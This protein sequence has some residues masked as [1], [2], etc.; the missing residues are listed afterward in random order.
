MIKIKI[1]T[2]ILILIL[3]FLLL[4]VA[5][6]SIDHVIICELYPDTYTYRDADEYMAIY[7]PTNQTIDIS[8]WTISDGEGIITFP[9]GSNIAE[10]QKLLITKN[11]VQFRKESKGVPDFEYGATDLN[12]TQMSGGK[13]QL[14][15]GGDEL[16]LSDNEGKPVDVVIYGDSGYIGQGWHGPSIGR[17]YEGVI[18]ERDIEEE[19]LDT[20]SMGDWNDLR[21]YY[22][23]QSHFPVNSF[24]FSGTV[25]VFVSPDCSYEVVT[26]AIDGSKKSL[27]IC[28][29][30]FNNIGIAKHVIN[31]K[32]R[33]VDVRMLLEG[34]PVDA[35]SQESRIVSNEIANAG[36]HVSFMIENETVHDRYRYIHAKYI[37]ID[38]KTTL[39]TTENFKYTGIPKDNS[40]G[41]RGWGI[42]IE[43]ANVTSYFLDVF[44]DDCTGDDIFVAKVKVKTEV[45]EFEVDVQEEPKIQLGD[46]NPIFK[47]KKIYGNFTVT[48]VIAPDTALLNETVLGL[49][50]S[51]KSSIYIEQNYIHKKWGDDPNL[52]LEAVID[53]A[54]RGC[55][56][57]ILLDNSWYNTD[58]NSEVML[59]LNK[60]AEDENLE[61]Q[62]RFVRD[63]LNVEK[64]H[65]KGV[66]IDG[67]KTFISSINWNKNSPARNRE[68]G[69]I[70]ENSEVSDYYTDIF[71][72]DFGNARNISDYKDNEDDR[73]RDEPISVIIAL[74]VA[75]L[76]V[77]AGL[78]A[79][80]RYLE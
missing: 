23:G 27:Y 50:N 71:M 79:I 20:D 43:D 4:P 67:N 56:V 28:A 41:N 36:G 54:R 18:F 60:L 76:V 19:I 32:R 46:Y 17:A 38:N 3:I 69:V 64:L 7:N 65:T 44:E 26:E 31:A 55:E 1:V 45:E 8:G 35:V 14:R 21:V 63:D 66:I 24:N 11:A 37:L 42:I 53:A 33:G 16:L 58:S 74:I 70:V 12:V 61:I 39:I 40:F 10:N 68:V 48:P 6:A 78:Y 9:K 29:Y 75:I 57:K 72:Y 5:L 80:R 34:G 25:C 49:I 15:N 73:D 13:I 52:Y 30:E 59:Y 2:G 47:S 22:L 62:V 77:G 51:A